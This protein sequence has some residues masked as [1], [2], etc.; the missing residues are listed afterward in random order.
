MATSTDLRSA[1]REIREVMNPEQAKPDLDEALRR[2]RENW[3]GKFEER[4][5]SMPW[6]LLSTLTH[7]ALLLLAATLA[8]AVPQPK[9]EEVV[10]ICAA[11]PRPPIEE[12]VRTRRPAF[13][14]ETTLLKHIEENLMLPTLTDLTKSELI[15]VDEEEIVIPDD[16][17]PQGNPN[18]FAGIPLGGS[19]AYSSL[20]STAALRSGEWGYIR[21]DGRER[22][23]KR[24]GGGPDT[25]NSVDIALEW[26]ARN[27]EADGHWDS[28]KHDITSKSRPAHT[29]D[30]ADTALALLAFL[31]SGHT[32]KHGKYKD[33]VRR[34]TLWLMR[35]QAANGAFYRKTGGHKESAGYQHAICGLALAEVYGMTRNQKVG[36]AA[37]KALNYSID[38][39]QTPYSGWRY[40]PRGGADL[41]VS[42][43]FVMQLKSAQMSGLRVNAAGYQGA[44]QF[45]RKVT[46]K[47]GRC[48]YTSNKG[49]NPTMTAV[50]MLCRQ[51]MGV[52][53]RDPMVRGAAGYLVRNLPHGGKKANPKTFYYW[54]YGT[55]S[56]FQYGGREW[57]Q[58]NA[59]MKKNLLS[60]QRTDG[61]A[62]GSWDP[63][64]RYD[65]VAGRVYTTAMG[66][67]TLEVYYRYLQMQPSR[68]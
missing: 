10:I 61:A 19:G 21:G 28:R 53:N 29:T 44:G 49:V 67:L 3:T 37:Q 58:W 64:G 30:R 5:G 26:L 7:G 36:V 57:K 46:D 4:I 25:L 22:Y 42:G 48:G 66:A 56:M 8:L 14:K 17:L 6:W 45:L 32:P 51:F 2:A 59:V 34:A 47:R 68:P 18:A 16:R 35:Q 27:Q 39:H 9:K 13:V 65:K 43:W 31:G 24:G 20:S 41:S 63:Q 38:K 1:I 11:D 12:L 62:R 52:D 60:S 23:A 33:N 50:G 55:L 54:Y 40:D 15:S